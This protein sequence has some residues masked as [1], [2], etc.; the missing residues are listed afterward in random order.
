MVR[1][2]ETI[3]EICYYSQERAHDEGN[4]KNRHTE[5]NGTVMG[6]DRTV[7]GPRS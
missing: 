4:A 1:S 7:D 3:R 6:P 5:H 2:G